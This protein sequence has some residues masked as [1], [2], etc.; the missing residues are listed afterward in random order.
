MSP[1][2]LFTDLDHMT[3][4]DIIEE[5]RE[6]CDIQ[7]KFEEIAV[8]VEE[9]AKMLGNVAE[10]LETIEK[11]KESFDEWARNFKDKFEKEGDIAEALRVYSS[12]LIFHAFRQ[13]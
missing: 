7:R 1:D 13:V 11:E 9:K 4:Y 6:F 8:V 2:A 12:F 10:E 5:A 3:G